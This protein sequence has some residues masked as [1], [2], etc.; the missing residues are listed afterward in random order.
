MSKALTITRDDCTA[1][2]L[3]EAASRGKDAERYGD[4]HGRQGRG[5]DEQ[6]VLP[7]ERQDLGTMP[8]PES[9]EPR[10]FGMV[11]NVSSNRRTRGSCDAAIDAGVSHATRRP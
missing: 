9:E 5:Y 7:Q 10:H 2:E 6:H 1:A 4:C 3:R 11:G 8:R